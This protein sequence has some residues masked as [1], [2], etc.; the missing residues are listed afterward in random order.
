[1][2]YNERNRRIGILRQLEAEYEELDRKVKLNQNRIDQLA[3]DLGTGDPKVAAVIQG[4]LQEQIRDLQTDL[5][6]INME[7]R[8]EATAREFL[9]ERGLP[10]D[11]RITLPGMT[12]LGAD[13]AGTGLDEPRQQLIAIQRQIRQFQAQ[14][15]DKNHPDLVALKKEESELSSMFTR[16]GQ[17]DENG[18]PVSPLE[19]LERQREKV[20]NEIKSLTDELFSTGTRMVSLERERMSIVS[21]EKIRDT[22]ALDIENKRVELNAPERVVVVQAATVPEQLDQALQMQLSGLGL[23]ATFGLVVAGFVLFEWF[24]QRA[25]SSADIAAH[26]GL[27]S[28]GSIPSPD[29]G[30]VMGTGLFSTSVEAEDWQRAVVESTDVVRTA[31]LRHV[32]PSRPALILVTSSVSEE[33]KT[34]VA[35]QLA[36]SLARI[37]RRVALVDCDFR[38]P[39]AHQFVN[40]RPGPGLSEFLRDEA[41]IDEICQ[42]TQAAGLTFIAAGKSDHA[43]LKALSNDGGKAVV[44]L[45]KSS[46]DFV[47][48]DSSPLLFVAEPSMLAQHADM[49]LMA[50]RKDHS[51][52]PYVVQGR[53]TLQNL[54]APLVGTVM[55]GAD[56]NLQRDSYGYSQSVSHAQSAAYSG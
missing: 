34:T 16:G 22:L 14:I 51:R 11:S 52:V 1:M 44:D 17:T 41:N 28:I 36:A 9:T 23:V 19:W 49:V 26:T 45:L 30:G 39:D 55:V 48:M 27:R 2:I 3:Q 37:G 6:D 4:Q 10:T 33:G 47:V 31:L 42:T 56:S 40:S 8:A 12:A 13:G 20:E 18:T 24:A 43:S 50:T 54:G 32:D 5:Q 25:G 15:R 38:S 7:I 21:S 53:D 46:F 35:S 29:N